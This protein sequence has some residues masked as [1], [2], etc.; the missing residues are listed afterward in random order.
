[1]ASNNPIAN[2]DEWDLFDGKGF[3]ALTGEYT[4]NIA[5]MTS[6]INTYRANTFNR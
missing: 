1:M 5:V 3:L 6:T 4:P 2:F